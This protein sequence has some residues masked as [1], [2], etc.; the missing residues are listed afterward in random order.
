MSMKSKLFPAI[1]LRH[2]FKWE[3]NK[4]KN[5][6][7]ETLEFHNF[8]ILGPQL[9]DYKQTADV[10]IQIIGFFLFQICQK[11]VRPRRQLNFIILNQPKHHY[12]CHYT[13]HYHT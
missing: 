5:F 9:V 10:G 6:D 4:N 11:S 1:L 13:D 12:M 7:D 3:R 8:P 2:N